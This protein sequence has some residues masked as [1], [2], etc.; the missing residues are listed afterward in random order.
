M[1]T[2][3]TPL[4][5][6]RYYFGDSVDGFTSGTLAKKLWKEYLDLYE[7]IDVE[8]EDEEGFSVNGEMIKRGYIMHD[9]RKG[10]DTPFYS[11]VVNYIA[12]EAYQQVEEGGAFG[13][14]SVDYFTVKVFAK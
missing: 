5:T 6:S 7:Q 2:Q 13:G 11:V 3:A 12:A 1:T 9:N 4:E 14:V 10:F 8:H